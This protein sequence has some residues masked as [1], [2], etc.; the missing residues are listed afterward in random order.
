MWLN[1]ADRPVAVIGTLPA[2]VRCATGSGKWG[3][4]LCQAG[5]NVR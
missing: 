5:E 1:V 2:Y 3:T 4:G